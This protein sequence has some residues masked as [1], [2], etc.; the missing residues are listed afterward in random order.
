MSDQVTPLTRPLPRRATAGRAAVARLRPTP[1]WDP[2]FA[3]ASANTPAMSDSHPSPPVA[4]SIQG[5]LALRFMLDTGVSAELALIP[6]E[7]P[8]PARRVAP[9]QD[10]DR[11]GV[12]RAGRTVA[13]P[14][15]RETPDADPRESTGLPDPRI[16]AARIAQALAE[17]FRGIR[18]ASQLRRWTTDE[19]YSH[20]RKRAQVNRVHEP[21]PKQAPR[22]AQRVV[23]R[24]VRVCE[25]SVGVV[26]AA[27]VVDDR[28]SVRALALRFEGSDGRWRCTLV[29][30]V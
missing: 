9:P 20:I 11:A 24:S 10:A 25:I 8:Q 23:I 21:G 19:V 5:T 2:P 3:D 14:V 22:M 29:H 26:E 13:L 27:A 7:R 30:E 16:W 15:G 4:A 18:P 28:Q 12:R 1:R 17:V 6:G